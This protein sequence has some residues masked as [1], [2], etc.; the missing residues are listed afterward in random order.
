MLSVI[1]RYIALA[2]LFIFVIP[3]QS[4]TAQKANFEQAER[5]TERMM[6]KMTGSTEVNPNWI[7]DQDRFWYSY[8][9][10]SGKHWYFVDAEEGE[11]RPLFD[12]QQMSAQL[13][14]IFNKPF[15]HKELDLKEFKYN[16]KDQLFTFHVDSI[17]FTYKLENNRLIKGDSVKKKERERWA[18]YSPDST[19]I[20][21]AKNHNLYLMQTDD[22]DSTEYQLT[23]SGERWYR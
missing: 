13:A 14:T 1:P 3:I 23:T 11:K 2:I 18:T 7:E 5:F 16:T 10:S 19:W 6:E 4:A 15:N 9:T 12:R 17:N 22:P 21:Y 20:A 8:D